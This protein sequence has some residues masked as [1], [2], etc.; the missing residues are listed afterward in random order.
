MKGAMHLVAERYVYSFRALCTNVAGQENAMSELDRVVSYNGGAE[1][2]N[3][4][5]P[6]CR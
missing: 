2:L 4:V 3:A 1:G 5:A 6:H